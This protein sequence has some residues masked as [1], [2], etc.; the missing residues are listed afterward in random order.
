MYSVWQSMHCR[1]YDNCKWYYH[2]DSGHV[3]LRISKTWNSE[4]PELV[5][6]DLKID[7][8]ESEVLIE[9]GEVHTPAANTRMISHKAPSQHI[10]FF[11]AQT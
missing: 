9:S 8:L 3:V 4:T 5:E 7:E 11:A 2:G 10:R 1:K 6:I